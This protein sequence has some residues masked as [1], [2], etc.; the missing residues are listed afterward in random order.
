MTPD[1]RAGAF[2]V[3]FGPGPIPD[4]PG[5]IHR[6]R[7]TAEQASRLVNGAVRT[8]RITASSAPAW[9]QRVLAAGREGGTAIATL[10]QLTPGP[11]G[12]LAGQMSGDDTI[13]AALYPEA[14]PE[15]PPR[16]PD[17]LAMHDQRRAWLAA[18]AADPREPERGQ[19]QAARQ[20]GHGMTV[21]LGT[22]ADPVSAG[23]RAKAAAAPGGPMTL[24]DG[25]R[26]AVRRV[27]DVPARAS[28]PPRPLICS[29][30]PASAGSSSWAANGEPRRREATA[31]GSPPAPAAGRREGQGPRGLVEGRALARPARI[32]RP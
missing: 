15:P 18:S 29:V 27:M 13:Y 19:I 24:D 32:R 21:G 23:I 4:P 8:G 20:D 10:L 12:S 16:E 26:R 22:A 2:T 11:D 31:C 9:R 3:T 17:W 30:S 14:P 5:A 28:K 25:L 1:P 6:M 7:F